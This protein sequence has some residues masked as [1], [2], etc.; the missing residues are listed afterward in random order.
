MGSDVSIFNMLLYVVVFEN[1]RSHFPHAIFVLRRSR[2]VPS[3]VVY[4]GRACPLYR[5]NLETYK[6]V[7]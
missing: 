7:L 1:V 2:C 5:E 4:L 6:D 3:C